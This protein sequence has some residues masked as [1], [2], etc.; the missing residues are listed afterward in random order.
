MECVVH[1][2]GD[3]GIVN[4]AELKKLILQTLA[5]GKDLGVD[6]EQANQLDVTALQLLWVL[7]R[8]ARASGRKLVLVGRIPEVISAA[9]TE[10]GFDHFPIPLGPGWKEA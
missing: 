4:A 9:A 6:L 1:L 3:V 10:A 2:E 5:T 7:A 8:E